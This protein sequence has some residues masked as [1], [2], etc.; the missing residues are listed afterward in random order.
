MPLYNIFVTYFVNM[1]EYKHNFCLDV[2]HWFL[3]LYNYRR[4]Y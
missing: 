3:Y 1:N 4:G 2:P